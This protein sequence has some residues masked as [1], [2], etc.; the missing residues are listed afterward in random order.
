VIVALITW[1]LGAS[2]YL[3]EIAG[4][5]PVAAYGLGLLSVLLL[6][7]SILAHEFGHALVARRRGGEVEE[8]D[9]WLLGGWS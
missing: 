8:I 5:A 6:F 9:L 3:S 4:I 1:E 2:Y 7:V